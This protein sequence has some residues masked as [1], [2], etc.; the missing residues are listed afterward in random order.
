L[1]AAALQ[2]IPYG[3]IA[4]LSPLGLAATL[5]EMRTGRLQAVGFAVGVVVGQL[6]ACALLVATGVAITPIKGKAHPTV[7]GLLA[8]AL[9]VSL[10]VFAFEVRRRPEPG[11]RSEPSRSKRALDRLQQVGPV[12]A[13]G[14]G[15]LLGIGG[16]KRLVLTTLAA[17]AITVAGQAGAPTAAL[18]VWYTLLATILVWGPVITYLFLGDAAVVLL[19]EGLEWFSR[20]RRRITVTALAFVGVLLV[21]EGVATLLAAS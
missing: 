11:I 20:H 10:L 9:G 19:D 16:P 12:T 8:V 18:V 7:E 6:L 2:L 3:L 21:I 15:S 5:L 13:A 14:I 1:G 17:A 4:T